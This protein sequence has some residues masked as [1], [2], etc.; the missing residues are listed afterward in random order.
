[1]LLL[2]LLPPCVQREYFTP[3]YT[4]IRGVQ[5][6]SKGFA[7][8]Y[9]SD[10]SLLQSTGFKWMGCEQTCAGPDDKLMEIH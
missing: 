10:V 4:Y 3:H 9:I 2:S 6:Q 1:M 8:L 7:V 5:I